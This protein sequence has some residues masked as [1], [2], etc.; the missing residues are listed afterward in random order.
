MISFRC[1]GKSKARKK[2]Q[3]QFKELII[4]LGC[5]SQFNWNTQIFLIFYNLETTGANIIDMYEKWGLTCISQYR[6]S[7]QTSIMDL[8]IND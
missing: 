4:G 6:T 5:P 1:V 3:I 7:T 2:M 8:R